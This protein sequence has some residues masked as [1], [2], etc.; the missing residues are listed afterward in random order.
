[1]SGDCVEQVALGDV[2]V[3]V[4]LV[5]CVGMIFE[6]TLLNLSLIVSIIKIRKSIIGS[7][8][9]LTFSYLKHSCRLHRT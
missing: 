5:I 6:K 2:V 4:S 1:M 3:F 9:I 7:K 8:T